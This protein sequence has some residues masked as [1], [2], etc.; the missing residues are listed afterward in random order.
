MAGLSSDGTVVTG[1]LCEDAHGTPDQ[2]MRCERWLGIR[3]PLRWG[4]PS[5]GY[6]DVVVDPVL[7]ADKPMPPEAIVIEP[8]SDTSEPLDASLTAEPESPNEVV[9]DEVTTS[10]DDTT[11]LPDG[12][13]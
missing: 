2:A 8:D 13:L 4:G 9:V 3:Q 7:G 5:K 10:A 6:V 11:T 1:C 12:N